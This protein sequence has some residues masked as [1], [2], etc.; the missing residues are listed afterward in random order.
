[1]KE[2]LTGGVGT[3]AVLLAILSAFT[4]YKFVDLQAADIVLLL[5]LLYCLS[6]FILQ[7]FRFRVVR[8]IRNLTLAYILLVFLLAFLS[9]LALRM[10]FFP[11]YHASFLKYPV[12]LSMSRLVQL[13]SMMCGFLWIANAMLR[14][15][16]L[17]ERV[18]RMYWLTGI[19]SCWLSVC[20]YAVIVIL[21][22]GSGSVLLLAAYATPNMVRARGFFV[23]GGPYGLYLL[24]V[25]LCGLM[26]KNAF[27]KHLGAFSLTVLVVA[28]VLS[29]SKAGFV[30]AIVLILY[31]LSL[32]LSMSRRILYGALAALLL[33]GVA[34]ILNIPDGILSYLNAYQTIEQQIAM[35][36][37]DPNLVL[38]RVANMY[39]IPRMIER[40]PFTGIGYGNYPLM[41]ND[42][43]YLGVL[44]SMRE[45]EDLNGI[46]LV[47]VAAETGIPAAILL[48]VMLFVPYW[49]S[50]GKILLAAQ[51]GLFQPIAYLMGVQLTF[52]YPWLL[53]ACALA[54]AGLTERIPF[55]KIECVPA[56]SRTM[57][58]R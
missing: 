32:G 49:R 35:R 47:G 23:E 41:R 5:I 51:A 50:R 1:M 24:S 44:P 53:S 22:L 14:S 52:F 38:G 27:R 6:K 40:H 12:V 3:I 10:Q 28:F 39:I 29:A 42:P 26:W 8:G 34:L 36:P 17:L 16:S 20:C 21:H 13:A 56:E 18:L 48:T 46:G 57:P 45:F 11:L 33:T 55:H 31:W 43:N 4:D 7:G 2:K 58:L 9:V 15:Q 30:A 19:L 54:L 37:D 25:L